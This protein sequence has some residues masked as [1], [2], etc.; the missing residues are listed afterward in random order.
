MDCPHC[1]APNPYELGREMA[2]GCRTFRCG[3]CTRTSNERTGTP[4]PMRPTR[5]P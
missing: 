2:L 1:A 3:A 4:L 5:R